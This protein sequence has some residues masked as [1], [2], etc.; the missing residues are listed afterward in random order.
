M[1][2]T[3]RNCNKS[4]NKH[5][6]VEIKNYQ[7]FSNNKYKCIWNKLRTNVNNQ[8]VNILM[9]HLQKVKR[10]LEA[11]NKRFIQKFTGKKWNR[12]TNVYK[13]KMSI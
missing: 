9:I 7:H 2:L 12:S 13:N 1:K 10:I 8:K 11:I 3:L 4:N 6:K 5:F